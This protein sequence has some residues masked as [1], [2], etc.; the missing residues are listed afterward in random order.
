MLN[1]FTQLPLFSVDP[2]VFFDEKALAART[3]AVNLLELVDVGKFLSSPGVW[4]GLVVCG[5]FATAAIYVRRYR[6]ES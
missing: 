2:E 5:L 1:R 4:L 3:D 6:G